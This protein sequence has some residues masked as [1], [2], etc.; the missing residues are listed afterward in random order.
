VTAPPAGCGLS[1]HRRPLSGAVSKNAKR[2]C[3]QGRAAYCRTACTAIRVD[4]SFGML[5]ILTAISMFAQDP[6]AK[7]IE[8]PGQGN[9]AYALLV[10][11]LDATSAI[12]TVRTVS[13]T[14]VSS[15]G[16]QNFMIDEATVDCDQRTV[17]LGNAVIYWLEPGDG[18]ITLPLEPGTRPIQAGSH[19]DLAC[20]W[21]DWSQDGAISYPYAS[22]FADAVRARH[23]QNNP[24]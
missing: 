1:E 24:G 2:T 3:I 4:P 7:W 12:R 9:R 15:P 8:V 19:F 11:R 13:V 18:P 10:S 17:T 5:E 16:G 20:S 23:A 6:V 14:K 21:P 22:D